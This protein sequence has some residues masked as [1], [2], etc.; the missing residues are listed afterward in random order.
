VYLESLLGHPR[1]ASTTC[2]A[3]ATL[4]TTATGGPH[5][6]RASHSICPPTWMRPCLAL[7]ALYSCALP[8]SMHRDVSS[9]AY[10]L[11]IGRPLPT[12]PSYLFYLEIGGCDDDRPTSCPVPDKTLKPTDILV[13]PMLLSH[14]Q[15][16]NLGIRN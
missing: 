7:T 9:A 8:P 6:T 13:A 10:H 2:A 15:R 4:W 12:C 1:H 3:L 16:T 5:A 11:I 14:P